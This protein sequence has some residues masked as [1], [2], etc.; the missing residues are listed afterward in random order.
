M[1]K[2]CAYHASSLALMDH[3]GCAQLGWKVVQF[4][5]SKMF[6]DANVQNTFISLSRS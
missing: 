4:F 1:I 6:A 5:F 2:A 3:F